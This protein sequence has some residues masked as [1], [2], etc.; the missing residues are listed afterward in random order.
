MIQVDGKSLEATILQLMA[1]IV[2]RILPLEA[3][4]HLHL[5]QVQL[6]I[7]IVFGV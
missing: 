5:L 6:Q 7:V 4:L 2:F 3:L 1:Q